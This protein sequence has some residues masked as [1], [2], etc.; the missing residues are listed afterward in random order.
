M[1]LYKNFIGI[2]IGKLSFTVALHSNKKTQEYKNNAQ[3]IDSFLNDYKNY[4]P[5]SLCV[6]EPTGGYELELL[7][8]LTNKD[9]LV[10][11][12]HTKYVKNFIRSFSNAVKTDRLDAKALAHYGFERHST[13][14]VFSKP[15]EQSLELFSLVQRRLDLKDMLVAEKNRRKAPH[16]SQL[17]RSYDE[18]IHMLQVQQEYVVK[19]INEII[20]NNKQLSAKKEVLKS[21]PGIGEIIA[22]DLLAL[23]PELG[24]LN[25]RQIAALVGVAPQAKESGNYKGYR[26]TGY[27]RKAVKSLL[28]MAA[29]SAA[30]SKTQL[31]VYYESLLSK[32]KKKMVAL[33]ALMRKIIVIANARLKELNQGT[34]LAKV[35]P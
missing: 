15:C 18:V 5:E 31:K 14:S 35:E 27:G 20:G 22:N 24:E 1:Q 12:A 17:D 2:D 21:I 34:A 11:R 13:L 25:R 4:L 32:G 19:K 9:F 8:T 30:R 28:F 3:G 6:L 23:L 33:V 10:H 26:R 29:M 7:F 16:M